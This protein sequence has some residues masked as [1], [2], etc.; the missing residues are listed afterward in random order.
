VGAT[1]ICQKHAPASTK[2][3]KVVIGSYCSSVVAIIGDSM[4]DEPVDLLWLDRNDYD[5]IHVESVALGYSRIKQLTPDLVVVFM[6]IDD[7]AAC[8]LLSMLTMD[9]D[10]SGIPVVMYVSGRKTVTRG[11]HRRR[12]P[13]PLE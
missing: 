4:R 3:S 1:F 7:S 8:R 9:G 6:A 10:V 11:H 13:M 12:Q 5:V 2:G